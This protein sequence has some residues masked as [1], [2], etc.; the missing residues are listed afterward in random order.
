MVKSTNDNP[1]AKVSL[2]IKWPFEITTWKGHLLSS[3]NNILSMSSNFAQWHCSLNIYIFEI[4]N[5]V[6]AGVM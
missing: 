3:K 1:E 2:L 4:F 5:L 6:W